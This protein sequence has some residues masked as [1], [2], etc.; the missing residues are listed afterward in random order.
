MGDC[1]SDRMI[2]AGDYDRDMERT[3]DGIFKYEPFKSFKDMFNI[4]IIYAVSENEIV[5][6]STVFGS[7]PDRVENG[8][9]I[10][11]DY[12]TN[13]Y[14]YS[15]AASVKGDQREIVTIVVFNSEINDGAVRHFISTSAEGEVF[16]YHN[17]LNWDDYHGGENIAFLSGPTTSGYEETV[18]HELGHAF[19]NLADEYFS[20]GEISEYAKNDLLYI[21]PYGMWKNIDVTGVGVYEGGNLYAKGIWRPSANSIMRGMTGQFNAPSR[22]AIYYRIH[23]LAYGK[24]WPYDYDA[25]VQWDQKNIEA[26]KAAMLAPRAS[27][28]K[29][30]SISVR[31]PFFNISQGYGSKGQ[32]G[33]VIIMN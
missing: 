11:A 33:T 28:R 22:E 5:G 4:Y 31:K 7:H 17:D 8:G 6:K 15:H 25:F 14:A 2:A 10:G 3:I 26:D 32:K 27:Q 9:A 23:K 20:E 16:D 24:D 21:F 13:I 18:I 30:S 29:A 19:G 1:Y 12:I